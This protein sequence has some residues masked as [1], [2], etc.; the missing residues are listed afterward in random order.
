MVCGSVW[1]V[2]GVCECVWPMSNNEVVL[3]R[4]RDRKTER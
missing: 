3:E 4:E 2:L 1:G